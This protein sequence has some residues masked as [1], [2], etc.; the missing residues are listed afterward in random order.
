MKYMFSLLFV[1]AVMFLMITPL[2]AVKDVRGGGTV[3][4]YQVVSV[5]VR[6][7]VVTA[8]EVATGNTV[9]FRMPPSSFIRQTF[10]ADLKNVK[11]GKRFAVRGARNSR[12][13]N[14][15]MKTPVK[16][17]K[18]RKMRRPVKSLRM[19]KGR[20]A[21]LPWAI[22]HVDGSKWIVKA[23]NSRTGKVIAFKVDPNGFKGLRFYAS[24]QGIR[25]GRG[26]AI[27]TPDDFNLARCCT[28]IK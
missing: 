27:M 16:M 2:Q 18:T 1:L 10:A 26:F 28:L 22:T 7:W 25:K 19:N 3:L 24:L 23:K 5:D 6:T 17:M 9:K 20:A 15:V 11:R 8:K 21:R 4:E 12:L 14:M 13:Q